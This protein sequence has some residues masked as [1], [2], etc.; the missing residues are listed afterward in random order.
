[1]AVHKIHI[2]GLGI[3]ECQFS[4]KGRLRGSGNGTLKVN[5]KDVGEFNP[6]YLSADGRRGYELT[7]PEGQSFRIITDSE[8][9]AIRELISHRP[10]L[11]PKPTPS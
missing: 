6:N 11:F 3:Y 1:M 5:G 8:R 4:K 9:S 2:A 7:L 10:A